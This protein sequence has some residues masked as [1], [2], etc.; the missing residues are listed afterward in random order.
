MGDR[1]SLEIL[2]TANRWIVGQRGI[3][4]KFMLALVAVVDQVHKR[5]TVCYDLFLEF[6]AQSL[7]GVETVMSA[8]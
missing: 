6:T 3:K 4:D 2:L 7:K 5:T 1:C 8:C